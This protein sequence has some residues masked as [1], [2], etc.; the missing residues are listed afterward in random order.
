VCYSKLLNTKCFITIA[1]QLYFCICYYDGPR[2]PGEIGIEWDSQLLVHVFHVNL[3]GD[4]ISNINGNT[5]VL[6]HVSKKVGLEVNTE[7]TKCMLRGPHH[8]SGG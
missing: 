3:S 1:F 7:K 8:S 5:E 6:I 2:K 4:D